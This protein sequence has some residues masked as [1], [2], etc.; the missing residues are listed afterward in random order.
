VNA[1]ISTKK[2]GVG[3]GLNKKTAEQEAAK[4]TLEELGEI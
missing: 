2:Y 4:K 3:K 1:L